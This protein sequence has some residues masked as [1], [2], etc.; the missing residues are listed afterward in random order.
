MPRGEAGG[1][2][3]RAHVGAPVIDRLTEPV[4]AP[5]SCTVDRPSAQRCAHAASA[6]VRGNV[7][8]YVAGALEERPGHDPVAVEDSDPVGVG[9]EPLGRRVREQVGSLPHQLSAVDELARVDHRDRVVDV[10]ERERSGREALGK[11]HAVCHPGHRSGAT[12]P[13]NRLHHLEG[14]ANVVEVLVG[15]ERD[16]I[17]AAQVDEHVLGEHDVGVERPVS[18]GMTLADECDG[19]G[20]AL[21][22]EHLA[23]A[24][25]DALRVAVREG[26]RTSVPVVRDDPHPA[27]PLGGQDRLD[28]EAEP[29][30][31]DR[32]R[33][34]VVLAPGDE[35]R[36]R[37]VER[38]VL[39]GIR[40]QLVLTSGERRDLPADR[41]PCV[42]LSS[43]PTLVPLAPVGVAEP[44]HQMLGNVVRA[45]RAV[46]VDQDRTHRQHD[47]R[48]P[49]DRW[50][51][52][53]P[54]TI[55]RP[56]R[57]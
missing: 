21:D 35:R 26:H 27:D 28:V 31:H 11:V 29:V 39:D 57:S 25:P 53:P 15:D 19:P 47:A 54:S 20:R 44:V 22:R 38:T 46:E 50:S 9:I 48:L 2:E 3:H 43:D 41:C 14:R 30:R 4:V 12:A 37:R 1:T 52:F 6:R 51:Y 56:A 16:A 45:R 40:D 49:G 32:G 5:G 18:V 23:R 7:D 17:V 33:D 36:E 8:P 24:A 10:V 55:R 13:G 34:V 42:D